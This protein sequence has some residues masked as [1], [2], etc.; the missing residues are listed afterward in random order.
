MAAAPARPEL[1]GDQ[2]R[3]RVRADLIVA[4]QI[5]ANCRPISG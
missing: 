1:R 5:L 3:A 2:V 4:T